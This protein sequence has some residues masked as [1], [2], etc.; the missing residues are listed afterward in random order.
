MRL[1]LKLTL[2]ILLGAWITQMV[3]LAL[4][5][6]RERT[7]F[8]SDVRKDHVILGRALT[9][10]LAKEWSTGGQASAMAMR[11]RMDDERQSVELSLV[12]LEQLEPETRSIVQRAEVHQAVATVHE[13]ESRLVTWVPLATSA[14]VLAALRLEESLEPAESYVRTTMVRAFVYA[15]IG[16]VAS[17]MLAF[18]FGFVLVGRRARLLVDKARRVGE[19]DLAG[20]LHDPGRDELSELARELNA[21][22]E[23]LAAAR[24][25]L[26]REA[27]QRLAAEQQLRHADRLSTVGTLAAGI[28][29]EL[30]TPLNIVVGRARLI[31][32]A[33]GA[34]EGV[35]ANA[36][37]IEE[38]T[39]RIIRI[40]RQLLDFARARRP[41]RSIV[42]LARLARETAD[43]LAPLAGKR[44]VELAVKTNGSVPIVSADPG[45]LQ[46]AVTNLVMN[47]VQAS[48]T[49]HVVELNVGSNPHTPQ[50]APRE[51]RI[52]VIDTGAGMTEEQQRNLFTPFFTTKDVGEG[53]GLGLA[54]A[55]SLVQENGGRISVEST[56]ARGSTFTIHL[57]A[58]A[59]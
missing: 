14:G 19:G 43:M 44:G 16:T 30:G 35:A 45:Q 47:A 34:S 17:T 25:E 4:R 52:S 26:E 39:Q 23:R 1:T 10:E 2:G 11:A 41:S 49:G 20:P 7:V 29:H 28:A 6:E 54:V 56:L 36:R 22:C 21:M 5:I 42:D 40:V 9:V 12:P 27:A 57:P 51:A 59:S 32:D 48:A 55:W 53:T 15:V 3:N 58:E 46:Q 50:G 33:A 13:D 18:V 38:Q 24:A 31:K 8:E 37:I